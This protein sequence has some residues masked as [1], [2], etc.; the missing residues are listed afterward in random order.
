MVFLV[1]STP[2]YGIIRPNQEGVQNMIGFLNIFAIQ[3]MYSSLSSVVNVLPDEMPVFV[4]ETTDSVYSPAAFYIS[5]ASFMVRGKYFS[6][7]FSS[8]IVVSFLN[9]LFIKECRFFFNP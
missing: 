2:Y 7:F 4:Q 3:V 1:I 5:K 8:K 6:I 9:W